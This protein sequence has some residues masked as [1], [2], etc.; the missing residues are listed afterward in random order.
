[1]DL[2]KAFDCLPHNLLLGNCE[3]TD[4][5]TLVRSYLSN[6]DQLVKLGPRYSDWAEIIKGVPQGSILGPLLFNIFIND[7]FHILD[8]SSLYNYADDNTLS[9]AHS[10]PDTLIRILQWGC[11]TTLRW[12]RVNQ[13]KANPDKF[14]AIYFGGRGITD[15]TSENTS[16]HCVD[17][18]VL[19]GIEIDHLLT[20]NKHIADIC[21]KSARHLVV[22]KCLG[23]LLTRQGKLAIFKSFIASSFNYCPLI[24]DF[25]SQ[26]S[27]DKLEKI[28]ERALRFINNDDSSTYND[29]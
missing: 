6:R 15:F 19:L 4:S 23:H 8:R 13:R 16:I 11:S 17:S 14:Q 25:C 9:H 21:K 7:I 10:N 2:S 22:L 29:F 12:F 27:T 24:W 28:Q 5:Q 18:V 1:M 26:A 20:F 3:H